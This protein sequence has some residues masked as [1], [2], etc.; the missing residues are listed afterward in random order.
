MY[1]YNPQQKDIYILLL[2]LFVILINDLISIF[3]IVYNNVI[4]T[5]IYHHLAVI[6]LCRR[7]YWPRNVASP[8][9]TKFSHSQDS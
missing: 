2:F 8:L 7:I 4:G 1:K 6:D 5:H 9:Q 3:P